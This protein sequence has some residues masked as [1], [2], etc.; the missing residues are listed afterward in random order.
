M[1]RPPFA[2]W[3]AFAGTDDF[4][5]L[6]HYGMDFKSGARRYEVGTLPFQDLAGMVESVGLILDLGVRNI[7]E[8]LRRLTEPL[9]DAARNGAFQLV[10]PVDDAHRS[11]IV[12]VRTDHSA[13]SYLALKRE[14]VV[15]AFREGAIRLSPHCY[16]TVDEL[17]RVAGIL[18]A[19]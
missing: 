19:R 5:S 14:S 1:V 10:S 6:T 18:G 17:E 11:A 9:F 2:G 16:N 3:F 7:A 15:C 13:E 8:Q 12:C 4:S